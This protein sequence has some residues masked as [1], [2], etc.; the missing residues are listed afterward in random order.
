MRLVATA[1][2]RALEQAAVDAGASW[3]TLMEQAGWG[4]AQAAVRLLR[5]P[6]GKRVLV[7]VGPGNNGGDGLVA[8][9]HLHDAGAHVAL[10]LWRRQA[11]PD[12]TNWA[13]CRARGIAEHA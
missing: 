4:V 13:R 6:N 11:S 2:M 1:Q 7:L 12:D 9:R 10:Y 8:A 5:H 3:A